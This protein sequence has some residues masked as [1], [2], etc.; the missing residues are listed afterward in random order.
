LYAIDYLH[1][2][3]CAALKSSRGAPTIAPEFAG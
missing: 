3:L 2:H 1:L